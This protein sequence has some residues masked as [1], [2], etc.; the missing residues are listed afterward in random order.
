MLHG[1]A[2]EQARLTSVLEAA[3]DGTS[4]VVVLRGEVGIG[5]TA[6]LDWL[7]G[8]EAARDFRVVRIAGVE[9]EA[10]L[11]LAGL[12]Q[13]AW[14]LREQLTTLAP[15]HAAVLRAAYGDGAADHSDRFAAG[16]AVL[17]LLAQAA[18]DRPLL[19]LVDDTHWLDD[20]SAQ[21]LGFAARRLAGERL[22]LVLATRGAAPAIPTAT[23]LDLGRLA[24]DQAAHLLTDRGLPQTAQPPIIAAAEGNPLAI[25]EIAAHEVPAAHDGTPLPVAD[26]VAARFRDQLVGLPSQA[27]LLALI[28]AADG[29]RSTVTVAAAAAALG[30]DL[31]DLASAER[32]GLVQATGEQVRF[33]HPLLTTVIYQDAPAA[34]RAEVHR[35]LA[36][37]TDDP[38]RRAQHLAA[39]TLV[40]DEPIAKEVSAAGS[41]LAGCGAPA[42]GSRLLARAAELT[43]DVSLRAERLLAA[44]DAAL[45]GGDAAAAAALAERAEPVTTGDVTRRLRIL[46][47]AE[48]ERGHP[49]RAARLLLDGA[50]VAAADVAFGLYATAASY[51]WFATDPSPV[52]AAAEQLQARGHEDCKVSGFA[53][54]VAGSYEA[55]LRHLSAAV[56]CARSSGATA[57][58][59]VLLHGAYA[60][61]VLGDDDAVLELTAAGIEQAR[62]RGDLG[63][64]P[65][66]LHARSSAEFRAGRMRDAKVSATEALTL[67]RDAGLPTR[68]SSAEVALAWP[69]A[70]EGDE[71]R[72][73]ALTS[74]LDD[75]GRVSAACALSL[76]D[77]G[78]GRVDQAL[79]RLEAARSAPGHH[80]TVLMAST[81]DL[82]EAAVRLGVP[83]RAEHPLAEFEQWAAAGGQPWARAVAAR[84]RALLD[85]SDEA[86]E[87]ALAAHALGGRPLERARTEL[88]YGSWLRRNRG[89]TAA[90][91]QLRAAEEGFTRLGAG[92]WLELTRAELRAAGARIRPA[93]ATAVDAVDRLTAQELQVVRLAAQGLAS[94]E[95]GERLFLSRRTV[96]YHLYKAYPKLGISSRRELAEVDL[97]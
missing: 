2:D 21:A 87:A 70:V 29:G 63:R 78:H 25:L 42:A 51:G 80:V 22:V 5:K 90:R 8:S 49:G 82:V 47:T 94:R 35:A 86:F 9:A 48:F 43:T 4:G 38:A 24:P 13:L 39:G 79:R 75:T 44:A 89:A 59:D 16:L 55:G 71:A 68:A 65:R 11:G 52:T 12:S 85:P 88:A 97:Q 23:T 92:P 91:D 45:A 96:E 28:A 7:A 41:R 40:P 58:P 15:R 19:C 83:E 72:L 74:R 27:R 69:A 50:A 84:S 61:I 31:A 60:A 66:L 67:A 93:T 95:I 73:R 46:G 64:L 32:A 54:L 18:D 57:D 34:Q 17:H 6:L 56:A 30:A 3:L 62:D 36:G 20:A 37:V 14:L 1:R 81:G 53:D 10:A 26:R 33:R 76:S 77:L